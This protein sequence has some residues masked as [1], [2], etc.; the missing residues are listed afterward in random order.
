MVKKADAAPAKTIK[1]YASLSKDKP[2]TPI[3]E[4]LDQRLASRYSKSSLF[5]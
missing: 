5:F 2:T 1:Q 3:V 4:N